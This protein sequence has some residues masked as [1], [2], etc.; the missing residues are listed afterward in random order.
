MHDQVPGLAAGA[1][2]ADVVELEERRP[3]D[4]MLTVEP[5][6]QGDAP[7]DGGQARGA[8]GGDHGAG[9]VDQLAAVAPRAGGDH[10]DPAG[11]Q[12]RRA[13]GEDLGDPV[14]QG[15]QAVV[16]E[17]DRVAAVAVVEL[18]DSALAGADVAVDAGPVG[19]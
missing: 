17:V 18:G 10:H 8:A 7:L 13:A 14:Q 15:V 16:G 2:F 9:Q 6:E 3:G 4:Q 1:G 11:P 12:Q 19:G 5:G